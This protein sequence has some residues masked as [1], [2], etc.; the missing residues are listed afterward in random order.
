MRI[1]RED[2]IGI[3]TEL[4]MQYDYDKQYSI[5]MANQHKVDVLP[6]YNNVR[7]YNLSVD[8]LSSCFV[9]AEDVKSELDVFMW[10]Y[11][12]GRAENATM[13]DIGLFYDYLISNYDSVDIE[14]SITDKSKCVC[15]KSL[16]CQN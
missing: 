16:C 12:F 14:Y 3:I 15:N 8:M 10:D 2:F 1:A 6:T 13:G 9:S 4:R 7:L 11:N 5:V